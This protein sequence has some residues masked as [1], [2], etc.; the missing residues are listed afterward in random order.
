MAKFTVLFFLLWM[1]TSRSRIYGHG[2]AGVE[3][4]TDW[5]NTFPVPRLFSEFTG[6]IMPIFTPPTF[7]Q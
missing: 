7:T 5:P 3:A 2:I 4:N 1:G 6:L